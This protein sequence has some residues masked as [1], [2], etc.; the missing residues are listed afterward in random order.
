ME[1]RTDDQKLQ[2]DYVKEGA[3]RTVEGNMELHVVEGAEISR[4]PCPIPVD[5]LQTCPP[6]AS[7][8]QP[9]DLQRACDPNPDIVCRQ[10]GSNLGDSDDGGVTTMDAVPLL[11]ALSAEEFS[12]SYLDSAVDIPMIDDDEEDE[13]GVVASRAVIEPHRQILSVTPTATYVLETIIP[14]TEETVVDGPTEDLGQQTPVTATATVPLKSALRKNKTKSKKGLKVSF[15]DTR[16]FYIDTEAETTAEPQLYTVHSLD[17]PLT[18]GDYRVFIPEYDFMPTVTPA[19]HDGDKRTYSYENAVV[20]LPNGSTDAD[21]DR[22]PSGESDDV[23][24]D[25]AKTPEGAPPMCKDSPEEVIHA[26]LAVQESDDEQ[27]VQSLTEANLRQHEMLMEQDVMQDAVQDE[28]KVTVPEAQ[29]TE[30]V[31]VTA[32]PPPPPLQTPCGGKTLSPPLKELTVDVGAIAVVGSATGS[33]DGGGE[34]GDGIANWQ[35]E[36]SPLNSIPDSETDSSTSSQDTMIM[37]TSEESR[38]NEEHIRHSTLAYQQA[39]KLEEAKNNNMNNN[40]DASSVGSGSQDSDETLKCDESIDPNYRPAWMKAID[41]EDTCQRTLNQ[42]TSSQIRQLMERNAVR[43]SLMRYSNTRKKTGDDLPIEKQRQWQSHESLLD[44]IKQLTIDNEGNDEVSVE[45]LETG[46]RTFVKENGVDAVN[47]NGHLE[48]N[49]FHYSDQDQSSSLY[50]SKKKST[51]NL[52]L[53]DSCSLIAYPS[54]IEDVL[55]RRSQSTTN[56]AVPGDIRQ[57]KIQSNRWNSV[58]GNALRNAESVPS[59]S[60]AE[61]PPTARDFGVGANH[62]YSENEYFRTSSSSLPPEAPYSRPWEPNEPSDELA[63]FVQQD[64]DRIERLRK[65]YSYTDG[66]DYD[67]VNAFARRPSV[68]GIKPR[69]GSTTEI[70]KQMQ[71]QLQP[72]LLTN[73]PNGRNHMTWPYPE[74]RQSAEAVNGRVNFSTLPRPP[75][76][77]MA[78]SRMLPVV[79]EEIC[80]PVM[81]PSQRPSDAAKPYLRARRGRE[82]IYGHLDGPPPYQPPPPAPTVNVPAQPPP[83]PSNVAVQYG[84]P[85]RAQAVTVPTAVAH[86]SPVRVQAKDERGVPEGASS[87]PKIAFD[88]MYHSVA[89]STVKSQV[90]APSTLVDNSGTKQNRRRI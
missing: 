38:R 66:S 57:W 64:S 19:D 87:S 65:R 12:K 21:D 3:V 4:P 8:E 16:V 48:A 13:D 11:R 37:M 10:L 61:V 33:G 41:V 60:H 59:V 90:G 45:E 34:S 70:L 36:L 42:R 69:F 40:N 71:S 73:P 31:A 26:T 47:G 6:Q 20:T 83:T 25:A 28:V 56:V 77:T 82:G 15:Q 43:R 80:A 24:D 76:T 62:R 44:T 72:Q 88:S 52:S 74:V 50:G 22:R 63:E 9:E 85:H 68:R 14:T 46:V 49:G 5:L 18:A 84:Y 29:P 89:P 1:L 32:P 75:P 78:S 27:P 54:V 55:H 67:A 7:R 2:S 51:S 81:P 35:V 58:R 86:A 23:G 39:C 79:K 30:P 17:L 53:Q